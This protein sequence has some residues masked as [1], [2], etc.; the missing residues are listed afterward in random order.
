MQKI[1]ATQN[2][3]DVLVM[4]ELMRLQRDQSLLESLYRRLPDA[5]A[6]PQ[7]DAR[8]LTL[9]SDVEKRADRLEFML[10]HM[11]Y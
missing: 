11:A 8:F 1:Q 3:M 10:D 6:Q 4:A 5:T 7:I 2:G 9:W